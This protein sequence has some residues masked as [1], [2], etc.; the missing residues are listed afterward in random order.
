MIKTQSKERKQ[1]PEIPASVR[2]VSDSRLWKVV[3]VGWIPK[4]TWG[5]CMR[6]AGRVCLQEITGCY[7]PRPGVILSHGR[8]LGGGE[9]AR[10]QGKKPN[11]HLN[12]VDLDKIL[13][14]AWDRIFQDYLEFFLLRCSQN[15][16]NHT[17][18]EFINSGLL[19]GRMGHLSAGF[20]PSLVVGLPCGINSTRLARS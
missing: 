5:T 17:S 13:Q 1:C 19:M 6:E 7:F 14:S 2:L 15:W 11:N 20:S 3:I 9:M 4:A 16:T 18:W 8:W 10:I 12:K